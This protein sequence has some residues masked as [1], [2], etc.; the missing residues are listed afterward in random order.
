MPEPLPESVHQATL[1]IMGVDLKVHV[2]GDGRRIIES[3]SLADFLDAM[4][5][6]PRLTE[7]EADSLARFVKG[8]DGHA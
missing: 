1:R 2:L 5:N 6:G 3:D 7:E 8:L 4:A